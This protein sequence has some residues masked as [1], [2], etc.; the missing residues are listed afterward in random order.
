MNKNSAM[1]TNGTVLRRS[2]V[3]ANQPA[4]ARCVA[5]APASAA[6]LKGNPCRDSGPLGSLSQPA[7]ASG[8]PMAGVAALSRG[9]PQA[10]LDKLGER[11]AFERCGTRIYDVIVAKLEAASQDQLGPVDVAVVKRFRQEVA[12]HALM[13]RDVVAKLGGDPTRLMPGATG[14]GM[15]PL[16]LLQS[17]SDRRTSVVGCLHSL[18]AVEQCG[19]AEWDVLVQLADDLGHQGLTDRFRLANAEEAAHLEQVREWLSLFEIEASQF[20]L[21]TA[22][23]GQRPT[24][25]LALPLGGR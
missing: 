15:Q 12:A 17:V 16:G 10:L 24:R 13:I 11:L 5:P 19:G 20:A 21:P 3:E 9:Y 2:A 8:V 22:A 23:V 25:N 18:L 14:A 7:S 6:A 4:R 1:G